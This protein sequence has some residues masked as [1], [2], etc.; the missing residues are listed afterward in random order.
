MEQLAGRVLDPAVLAAL[1]EVIRRRNT[2][3]FLDE[4]P[5]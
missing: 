4:A 3:T 2:L 1:G 5:G